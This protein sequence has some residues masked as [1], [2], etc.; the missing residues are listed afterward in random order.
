M[1]TTC[2]G[3]R[4]FQSPSSFS[5]GGHKHGLSWRWEVQ[6]MT[7]VP[8]LLLS[9]P[10]AFISSFSWQH[11][12]LFYSSK[13][14]CLWFTMYRKEIRSQYILPWTLVR[15]LMRPL[16]TLRWSRIRVELHVAR[17]GHALPRVHQLD[18]SP[19]VIPYLVQAYLFQSVRVLGPVRRHGGAPRPLLSPTRSCSPRS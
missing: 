11:V 1:F 14:L 3:G 18:S 12:F 8:T 15:C 5:D 6:T 13:H 7:S 9:C 16:Q 17:P 19:Q 4:Y 10:W 2:T